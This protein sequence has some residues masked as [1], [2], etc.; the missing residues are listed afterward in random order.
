MVRLRSDPITA[1]DLSQYVVQKSSD[2]AFELQTLK[3]LRAQGLECQ[4]GGLYEDPVTKRAR[5]FDIRAIARVKNHCV[6]LAIECKNVGENCPSL[7]SRVP[8]HPSESFHEIAIVGEIENGR[9]G[10][11]L[12]E[13][14]AHIVRVGEPEGLYRAYAPV[15]KSLAQIGRED[16]REGRLWAA[17]DE[18]F[19]KWAQALTSADDLVTE[20]YYEGS[21]DSPGISYVAVLPIVVV[22]DGRLWTVDFD[23]DGTLTNGPTQTDQCSLFV[24]HAYRMEING[25]NFQVSH[26]EFLTLSRLGEF[27]VKHLKNRT[28]MKRIFPRG[29]I[30]AA[31][32]DLRAGH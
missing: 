19:N 25:P 31:E 17:D 11:G 28:A 12:L 30:E 20:S 26:V 13:I 2:F 6:R 18:I 27:V 8:R 22:P 4:H 29:T 1:S 7:I 16:H 14:R 15:G 10:F 24:N 3:L 9:R 32:D 23:S 21:D 5:Q